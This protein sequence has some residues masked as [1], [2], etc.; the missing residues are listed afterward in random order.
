MECDEDEDETSELVGEGGETSK[1]DR[2]DVG[3]GG[4]GGADVHGDVGLEGGGVVVG[5]WEGVMDG[6]LGK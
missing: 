1:G 2:T 6:S 4:V 3:E 5:S